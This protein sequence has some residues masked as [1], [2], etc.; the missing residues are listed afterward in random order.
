MDYCC[1]HVTHRCH[2]RE[3]LLK[4]AQDRQTYTEL[5]REMLRRF[6]VDLLNY[7]ITSNHIHLLF[8]V[9]N[10]PELSRAMQ[11]V[12]GEF[13]QYYNKRKSREGA[14]WRDRYH[15]TLIESGEHLARCL[16]Y[17]DLNMVRAGVVSHPTEWKHG[18]H[19]ELAGTRQRYRLLNLGRL[20]R[21]LGHMDE[22]PEAF[23]AWYVDTLTE[24]LAAGVQGRE[25]YWTEAFAVGNRG[26]VEDIY[27]RFGFQRKKVLAASTPAFQ[28]YPDSDTS[29]A[30]LAD[31]DAVYYIEG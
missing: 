10:G 25:A 11:F 12:Q 21:C 28:A 1:Y 9:Q 5:L 16:F 22:D 4:F 7:T 6:K 19:H 18:G 8:W 3:F 13:G 27:E 30:E 14:F 26:W 24:K 23:R 17:I 20:L 15:S 29:G 2:K 31:G